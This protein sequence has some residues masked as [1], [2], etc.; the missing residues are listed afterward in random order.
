[1]SG[2]WASVA[3]AVAAVLTLGGL[4]ACSSGG[5]SASVPTP[6]TDVSPSDTGAPS[7]SGPASASVSAP[8]SVAP[9]AGAPAPPAVPGYLL[10]PSTAAVVRKFQ[11]VAGDSKGVFSGLTVRNVT[12]GTEVTGTL[13]LLSLDP[14]LVGNAEVEKGLL[15]GMIKGMTGKGARTTT[16]KV[17]DR[18]VAVASTETTSVI[19]WY[20]RGIV[21]LM[22]GSSAN[23]TSPLAFAKAYP[24][25]H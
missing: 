1:V 2:S 14:Q 18:S 10:A 4:T 24:A 20:E 5:V 25:P 6:L 3:V 8:A 23:T 19:A 21:A 17:G 16:Q 12:K 13:V 22:L 11:Q 7:A 9:S 15:P